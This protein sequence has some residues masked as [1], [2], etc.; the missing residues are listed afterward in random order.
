MLF[1]SCGGHLVRDPAASA[2]EANYPTAEFRLCGQLNHGS[3]V[4]M[5]PEGIDPSL[6]IQGYYNG[7][8]KISS[9]DC[10]IDGPTT[11]NYTENQ[12]VPIQFK[13]NLDSCYVQFVVI[14]EYPRQNNS[15]IDVY[16]FKGA[17]YIRRIPRGTE[18][19]GGAIRVR[20]SWDETYYYQLQGED[21]G[22][23]R[24]VFSGCGAN[25]DSTIFIN[26]GSFSITLKEIIS[27]QEVRTC[28]LNGGLIFGDRKIRISHIVSI[29]DIEYQ[30]LAIPSW[31]INKSKL[32]VRFDPSVSI[33]SLNKKYK[34]K[35]EYTFKFDTDSFNILRG[36]TVKGRS[37]IGTWNP[38]IQQFTWSQ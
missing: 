12:L 26:N 27:T 3:A 1:A 22:Q 38:K 25:Y 19:N 30:Q 11:L 17:L 24:L 28:V 29:Y 15:A 37:V 8:I 9:P 14:P 34:L 6:I 35:R 21:S 13:H 5:L 31:E 10:A 18:T 16:N 32:K 33:V 36:I 2:F 4:C 20:Q 7:Q 23:A